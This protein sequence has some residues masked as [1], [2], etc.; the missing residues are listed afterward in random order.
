MNYR[1]LTVQQVYDE[2]EH[3]ADDAQTA[4][5]QLNAHQLNWKP[6]PAAW[7][8]QGLD[9]LIQANRAFDPIFDQILRGTYERSIMRSMPFGSSWR[10]NDATW[11]RPGG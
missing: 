9:H 10:M 6:A 3:I 2:A 7:S 5:G 4:F 1:T 8:A 11:H